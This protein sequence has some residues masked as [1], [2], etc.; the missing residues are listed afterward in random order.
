[1]F[2]L[3]SASLHVKN[4]LY[5]FGFILKTNDPNLNFVSLTY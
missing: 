2:K 1:M 4:I 3:T 5:Y